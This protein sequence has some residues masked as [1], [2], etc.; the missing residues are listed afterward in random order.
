MNRYLPYIAGLTSSV[1]FGFS[2]LF[3]KMA[4]DFTSPFY[5]LAY[6]F[7]FAFI[8]LFVL[9]L[10]GILKAKVTEKSLIDLGLLA[11]IQPLMYFSLEITGINLT[12]SVE[13][14]ILISTIPVFVLILSRIFLKEFLS[15]IQQFFM[16]LSLAGVILITISR[17]L[18]FSKS[19][20]GALFLI[21][22]SI[23]AAF[24][25]ILSRR[26]SLNYTP[27]DITYHMML[28]GFLGFTSVAFFWSLLKRET[29]EFVRELLIRE[30][31]ISVLYLGILSSAVTFFLLNFTLSRIPATR[32][33]VFPYI[34]TVVALFA[35]FVFRGERLTLLSMVGATMILL[36]VWWI[37]AFASKMKREVS[38]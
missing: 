25:N 9:K 37:N 6:R 29:F 18:H 16:F 12:T 5:F 2:F 28:F 3:T 7:S 26:A 32:A 13:A 21:A 38:E 14:G 8:F 34:S 36:G 19:L 27:A 35:G 10:S 30:V 1:I 33:S 20:V 15:G 22:C 4:I 24:Y 17:G 23:S 11:F 31:M